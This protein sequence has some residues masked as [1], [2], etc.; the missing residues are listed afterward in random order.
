MPLGERSQHGSA[1]GKLA[2]ETNQT[3]RSQCLVN[4]EET[5]G[6][7]ER[8]ILK[9]RETGRS[10]GIHGNGFLLAWALVRSN[11]ALRLR[12]ARP[13]GSFWWVCRRV[14]RYQ[15]VPETI[16]EGRLAS[17]KSVKSGRRRR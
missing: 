11:K 6:I 16:E 9:S 15:C 17:V 14:S 5:D 4:I 3:G 1:H 2:I 13:T 12:C 7:L 10:G 8:T